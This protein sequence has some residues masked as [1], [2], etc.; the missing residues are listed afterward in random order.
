MGIRWLPE[1]QAG[2]PSLTSDEVEGQDQSNKGRGVFM[3]QKPHVEWLHATPP[4]PTTINDFKNMMSHGM[5]KPGKGNPCLNFSGD[6]DAQDSYHLLVKDV[7]WGS[8][9]MPTR[10]T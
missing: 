1:L 5:V 9:K 6:G 7:D 10:P 2:I 4:K 8:V 3:D